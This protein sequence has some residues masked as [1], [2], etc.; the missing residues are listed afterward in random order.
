MTDRSTVRRPAAFLCALLA[1][2][3]GAPAIAPAQEPAGTLQDRIAAERRS[4]IVEAVQKLSPSVASVVVSGTQRVPIFNDP[5]YR[6]FWGIGPTRQQRY[7]MQSGSSV[8][9]S[10]DGEFIT[11]QHVVAGADSVALL[12]PDGETRPA[13]VI[14]T[15]AKLDIAL[16]K[17]DPHGLHPAALGASD[18]LMVGEWLVA[19]GYPVGGREVTGASRF[20]P[21]VT[22]GV[23]SALER[24]FTPSSQ[25]RTREQNFY[26]DMI[27]TDA[28]INPGNS[29]G[30]L[31]NAS[32]EVVGLNTFILSE[33][34]GSQGL[35]FAIPIERAL[36]A[37]DEIRRYGR[38]RDADFTDLEVATVYPR[39]SREA[40]DDWGLEEPRGLLVTNPGVAGN[41]GL[42]EGD[43]I[44]D[45]DGKRVD[46]FQE[47]QLALL[48]RFVGDRV[49][50]GVWRD[51]ARVEILLTLTEANIGQ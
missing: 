44:L 17:T 2:V 46:T 37:A 9:I 43:V 16:L 28:A 3:V 15:S 42:R 23:V 6:D 48:P 29:G 7:T 12:L 24:S 5:F 11:N 25:S 14:G 1:L 18:D 27:Q 47:A 39:M 32:G 13:E 4:V 31:A 51:R 20:Q 49:T 26:P 50:L 38:V 34:G 45:I 40:V 21:T 30:P 8:M 19:V 36:A 41:A 10:A 22:V 33:T 35:G